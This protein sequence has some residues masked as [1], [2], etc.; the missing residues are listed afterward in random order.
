MAVVEM[1]LMAEKDGEFGRRISFENPMMVFYGR[2]SFLHILTPLVKSTFLKPLTE[3][4]LTGAVFIFI[5][6]ILVLCFGA[7]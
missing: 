4:L 1:G 6:I 2:L 7:D 3:F 5:F